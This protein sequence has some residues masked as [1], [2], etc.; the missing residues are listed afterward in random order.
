MSEPQAG[1]SSQLSAA[2]AQATAQGNELLPQMLAHIRAVMNQEG[3]VLLAEIHYGM[4]M[5]YENFRRDARDVLVVRDFVDYY[6]ANA[7][8]VAG[9][10][11]KQLAEAPASDACAESKKTLE[12]LLRVL[13]DE[14]M[15]KCLANDTQDALVQAVTLQNV[16]K[17]EHG[18]GL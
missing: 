5:L 2:V 10:Y 12:E 17:V 9:T 13:R 18:Q 14:F 11:V 15:S 7:V 3:A 6:A 16:I 4:Q 8:K 1:V